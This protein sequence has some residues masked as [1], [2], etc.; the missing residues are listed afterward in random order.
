MQLG[1][2]FKLF[3]G[4]LEANFYVV[5]INTGRHKSYE[6]KLQDDVIGERC[7]FSH[8]YKY[9]T[10][11]SSNKWCINNIVSKDA[12]NLNIPQFNEEIKA[13]INIIN[14]KY[15]ET[16]KHKYLKESNDREEGIDHT[17]SMLF[18]Q[19]INVN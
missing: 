4:N 13:S 15:C 19:I 12:F 17:L 1:R 10:R 18:I 2:K 3:L 16:I 8:S 14:S 11:Y 9:W 5:M 7:N 6:Q